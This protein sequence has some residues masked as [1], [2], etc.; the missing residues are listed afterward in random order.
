MNT[1]AC[2]RVLVTSCCVVWLLAGTRLAAQQQIVDPDFKASVER[3]SY[4]RGGPTVAID[5]AHSNFHTAGGQYKPFADLLTADGYRVI[6]L[7]RK[8]DDRD[9]AGM[10]VLV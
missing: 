9:L 5:E 4:A 8:F 3:P 10:C 1:L 2:R 6:A 7:N